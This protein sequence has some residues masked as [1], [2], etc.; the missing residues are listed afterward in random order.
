MSDRDLIC[1][2]CGKEIEARGWTHEYS[3]FCDIPG[4]NADL[5]YAE[6]AAPVEPPV[7]SREKLEAMIAQVKERRRLEGDWFAL[8]ESK[9]MWALRDAI[10][11]SLSQEA[12][13]MSEEAE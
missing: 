12:G 13:A 5:Q 10:L 1:K 2:N 3:I 7:L 8:S 4:N 9:A 6:P 11:E